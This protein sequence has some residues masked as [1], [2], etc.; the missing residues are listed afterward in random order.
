MRRFGSTPSDSL[1][2]PAIALTTSCT[3]LRSNADIGSRRTGSPYSL[4][5]STAF[6][7]TAAS[8]L[9]RCAR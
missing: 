7:A 3:H 1:A 2:T 9:R 4:T 6:L 5:F 8:S